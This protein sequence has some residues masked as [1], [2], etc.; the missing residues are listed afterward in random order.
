M[1]TFILLFQL[2][3][4]S[5]KAHQPLHYQWSNFN[6][7]IISYQLFINQQL[8][9]KDMDVN[10]H[11]RLSNMNTDITWSYEGGP[12]GI[13]VSVAEVSNLHDL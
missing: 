4:N 9:V 13:G 10:E 6:A 2:T 7:V 8:V 12:T 1:A 5:R 3:S 11:E